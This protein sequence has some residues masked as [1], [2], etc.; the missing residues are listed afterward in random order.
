MISDLQ[1]QT[2]EEE[3]LA[4][5]ENATYLVEII[6]LS[7]S[8]LGDI[9]GPT[10]SQGTLIRWIAPSYRCSHLRPRVGVILKVALIS[11]GC[12]RVHTT[13]N[14]PFIGSDELIRLGGGDPNG[15]WILLVGGT[16]RTSE[17]TVRY[18]HS[19]NSNCD[20]VT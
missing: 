16:E 10:K 7:L 4:V 2:D 19:H 5:V 8:Q 14:R 6:Q 11:C 18:P 20:T 1:Y 15:R 13:R 17:L 9:W 3:S 12:L